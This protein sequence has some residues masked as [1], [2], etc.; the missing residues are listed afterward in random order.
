MRAMYRY[1]PKPYPSRITLFLTQDSAS[2]PLNNRVLAWGELAAGGVEVHT[3]PGNHTNM[4]WDPQARFLAE[5]LKLCIEKAYKPKAGLSA[6][7]SE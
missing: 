1:E 4:V 3:I 6:V 2:K 7:S 5:E